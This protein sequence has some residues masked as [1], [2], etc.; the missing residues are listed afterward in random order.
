MPQ[1]STLL[2]IAARVGNKVPLVLATQ[3]S[4]LLP[5]TTRS[6][7]HRHSAPARSEQMDKDDLCK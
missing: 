4:H 3:M 1:Q 2:N 7:S 5:N 6:G